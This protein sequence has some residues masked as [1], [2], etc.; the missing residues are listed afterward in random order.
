MKLF[1]TIDYTNGLDW[2]HTVPVTGTAHAIANHLFALART[3]DDSP[4]AVGIE[5]VL[6]DLS[7]DPYNPA[8]I[9]RSQDA[10]GERDFIILATLV[11]AVEL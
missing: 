4:S 9:I 1:A 3:L 8:F 10:S 6:E 2:A 11:A 7:D 5:Y